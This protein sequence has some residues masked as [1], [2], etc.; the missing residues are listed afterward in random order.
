MARQAR[1]VSPTDLYHVMMRGN[2]RESILAQDWQKAYFTEL[3]IQ[4]ENIEITAYCLMDNHVHLVVKAKIADLSEAVKKVN[5]KYAMRFNRSA[6]RI[7]HVFQ[8]RYRSEEILDDAHL[9]QVVR[10]VHNNPVKARVAK[11]PGEYPWSSFSEYISSTSWLT[12]QSQ[13]SFVM[14]LFSNNLEL[15]RQ[16]HQED[17]RSEF[18]DMREDI[19]HNRAQAAQAI[20]AG[21]CSAKGITDSK[22]ICGRD[23]CLDELLAQLLRGTKLSHR[24]IAKLLEISNSAV[25]KASLQIQAREK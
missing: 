18:L 17:D 3:M 11:D 21:F 6:D 9:L 20:I 23:T 24:D 25:H 2:N 15:F 8:D 19:E 7:G 13:M 4:M 1:R 5:I 14:K 10:Y 22:E 16:F 12:S